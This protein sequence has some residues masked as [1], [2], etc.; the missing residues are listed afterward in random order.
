MDERKIILKAEGKRFKSYREQSRLSQKEAA[1][2]LG[3]S[4]RTLGAY[5]RG[6][7]E[8]TFAMTVKMA[9]IYITTFA[10]LTAYKSICGNEDK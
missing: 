1:E 7:R 10:E 6:E 3:I 2:L 8:I 5:E 9:E 4:S